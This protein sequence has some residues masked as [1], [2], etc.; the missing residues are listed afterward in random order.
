VVVV[1]DVV[2][3]PHPVAALSLASLADLASISGTGASSA[4]EIVFSELR[5]D[6]D[7]FALARHAAS[8]PRRV[9]PV[10]VADLPDAPWSFTAEPS[11]RPSGALHPASA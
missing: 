5:S 9:V 6:D 8:S 7:A 10:V 4:V 2:S 3:E 11:L 1:G